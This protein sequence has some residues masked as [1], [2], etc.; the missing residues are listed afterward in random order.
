MGLMKRDE[1]VVSL[2]GGGWVVGEVVLSFFILGFLLWGFG[3]GSGGVEEFDF[4]AGVLGE[5]GGGFGIGGRRGGG[6]SW[7]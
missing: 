7:V 5:L 2:R 4:G 6:W 3:G 1:G